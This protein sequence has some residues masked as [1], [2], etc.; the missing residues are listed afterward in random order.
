MALHTLARRNNSEKLPASMQC[1]KPHYFKEGVIR[2]SLKQD[3]YPIYLAQLSL[4]FL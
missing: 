3:E 2:V 4:Q 1:H